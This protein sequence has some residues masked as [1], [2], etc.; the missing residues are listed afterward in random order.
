MGQ[1]NRQS[2]EQSDLYKHGHF[3]LVISLALAL[4]FLFNSY[5]VSSQSWSIGFVSLTIIYTIISIYQIMLI[6]LLRNDLLR[7]GEI[8]RRTRI[9]GSV[10]L[11]SLLVGNVFT[12]TFA[13]R[14]LKTES[15]INYT[16][17]YY[18]FITDFLV[19]GV[20]LLNLFKPYVSNHFILL[21]GILI[22]LLLIDIIV[23]IFL[24][25]YDQQLNQ[26]KK[27]MKWLAVF[28]LITS[29][30]GN[31][32][33]IILG[34][35]LW[36][37]NSK[38]D[39][40]S[41]DKWYFFWVK[42]NKSF[43]A[44]IGLLFITFTLSIS[45]TSHGT[46]V[47][48]FATANNYGD[49]L[50]EP[51]LV[52]P[53][54]TDN[55]GRD[56]FSRIIFG[57]RISLLIGLLTTLIPLVVGGILGALAGYYNHAIDQTIM[58][59]LDILYAIPGILLAIAIIAAFG[60]STVNLVIA[61]SIGSIPTYAR[62]MRAN[63]LMVANLDYIE[64]AKALGESDWVILIKHAI[65]NA[66]A[67]MIVRATLT[68]GSAVIAT[69]SLS[70]LGLGVEPHVPEWGN[71]LRIGSSYLETEPYLAIFPGLAIIL[72]VLAFNFFG[73]GLRDALD[74]KVN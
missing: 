42:L 64:A 32:F 68:I 15:S 69:G 29:L 57:A 56:V 65:P 3:S 36:L 8:Q 58:R 47:T 27:S 70:F 72:L 30:T 2:L 11:L 53:F 74:P 33:R 43:T 61:L 73:D 21:M 1:R 12:V 40:A 66:F 49:L 71:V 45:I 14:L 23:I 16:F 5:Q 31:I 41:I 4:L 18:L 26:F 37:Q 25:K 67:P 38:Q 46:F 20:T 54:G 52:H 24:I 55:F 17:A 59:F 28:L 50:M 62:T 34:Y 19:I 48:S 9:L 51:S 22:A 63:I 6:Y 7:N 44:M 60:S 35:S 13:F 39:Q 10:Q